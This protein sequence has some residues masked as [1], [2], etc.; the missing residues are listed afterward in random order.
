MPKPEKHV[1]ICSQARQLGECEQGAGAPSGMRP[2]ASR[3]PA[4]PQY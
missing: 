1:F 3:S 4:Q 2:A